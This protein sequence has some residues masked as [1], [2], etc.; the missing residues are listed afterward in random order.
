VLPYEKGDVRRF[1]GALRR[2]APGL[3]AAWWVLVALRGLLPAAFAL[4][5]GWLVSGVQDGDPLGPGLA[6]VG[7]L[8]VAQ[9]VTGPIHDALSTNLGA[10]LSNWLQERLLDACNGHPGLAHLESPAL[11]DRLSMA[12]DFDHGLSGPNIT[13]AMPY[14]G[15]GFAALAAGGAQALLLGGYRWWAPVVVGGGWL[16]THW[17]LKKGAIWLARTDEDVM[18]EQRRAEYAYRL[19]VHPPASKEVRLFGLADFIV[20]GFASLR[21]ALLDRSWAARRLGVRETWLAVVLVT[22]ANVVFFWSLAVDARAGRLD[23]GE[24]V[25]F[26]SAAIGAATLAFGEVDWWLRVSAQPVPLVLDLAEQMAATHRLGRQGARPADGMPASEIRFEDVGF[27]YPGTDRL[28]LD[29]FDLTLPAGRSLAIVGQ[30]GAGKTTLAKLLCRLYDPTSG[31]VL[32]DGV[33]LRDLDLD[34]WRA[35]VAAVF[36]DFVR[37]EL[38]LRENIDP[39]GAAG[40]ALVVAALDDARG[41]HLAH[42]LSGL[43]TPLAKAYPGGTDLSGGQWQ[44]VALARALAAV[45]V[46]AGVVLLDEPTA[47]LDVRG[48]VEVFE[49]LLAATRGCTTVLISHRFSTVRLAD[50]ICVVEGGRVIEHGTHAELMEL[51]G[52]YRTMFDLQASRF[53]EAEEDEDVELESL[54]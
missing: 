31:R 18:H 34:G 49:R 50:A 9:Q 19:A 35:R 10:R 1:Y 38:T 22:G 15:G 5:M 41:S 44:R 21:H 12:R 52:R 13:T 45:R 25:V 33:D 20:G 11:A 2:A 26:A 40:E 14:I 47:Q 51:G 39:A 30:N 16:S 42:H 53:G 4:A 7:V 29:G 8:F 27:A 36:Q 23:V 3:T 37:Y 32:V 24:L 17:L 54:G 43:D 48:E 46:G 28:V 6:L